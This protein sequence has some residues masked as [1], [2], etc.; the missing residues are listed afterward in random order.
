LPKDEQVTAALYDLLGR[1]VRL[2]LDEPHPAGIFALQWDGKNDAGSPVPSGV[3]LLQCRTH[4][5]VEIRKL[6]LI[7]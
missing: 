1:R 4:D 6:M 2:L 7:R 5:K 3:Y